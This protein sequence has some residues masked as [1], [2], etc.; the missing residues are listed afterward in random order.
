MLLFFHFLLCLVPFWLLFFILPVCYGYA[1]LFV[2]F[3][4]LS[5]MNEIIIVFSVGLVLKNLSETCLIVVLGSLVSVFLA[6]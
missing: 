2:N 5:I 6:K 3:V 1:Q 4:Y